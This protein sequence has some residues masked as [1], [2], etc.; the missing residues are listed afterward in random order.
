MVLEPGIQATHPKHV[1][2]DLLD[3]LLRA[4]ARIVPDVVVDLGMIREVVRKGIAGVGVED[5]GRRLK[6]PGV[7]SGR[8]LVNPHCSSSSCIACTTLMPFSSALTH[9]ASPSPRG[10]MA[11]GQFPACVLLP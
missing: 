5:A 11:S 3:A 9:I 2:L 8:F 10:R 4:L 7:N 6:N 1:L